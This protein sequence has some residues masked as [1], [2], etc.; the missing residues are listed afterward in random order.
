[1]LRFSATLGS[2]KRSDD[3]LL[4][5]LFDPARWRGVELL[6]GPRE[7]TYTPPSPPIEEAAAFV[8]VL[9]DVSS[10]SCLKNI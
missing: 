10:D 9:F 8:L 1:M 3:H 6:I 7:T 5:H 4:P 2:E